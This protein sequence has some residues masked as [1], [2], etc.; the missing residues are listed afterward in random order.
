MFSSA[1]VSRRTL[2]GGAVAA[3]AAGLL[4]ACDSADP[5]P[6]SPARTQE[7]TYVT[8]FGLFGREAYVH[9][10]KAKGYF[11][12]QDLAVKVEPGA[13]GPPNH[14]AVSSGAA[15]FASVDSTGAFE[16]HARGQDDEGAALDDLVVISAVQQLPL[17][18]IITLEGN[19]ITRPQD[20]EGKVV[21]GAAGSVI[22][23][24]FPAYANLAGFDPDSVRFEHT[25]PPQLPQVLAAGQV[26]AIGLFLVGQEAVASV[27]QREAV[28]L[29]Y[30][31]YMPDLYGAV[32]V[33]TAELAEQDPD[34]VRRFNTAILK[35]LEY[36]IA[37]PVEAGEILAESV[38]ETNVEVAASELESM[39]PYVRGGL[40][41]EQPTGVI[42][43]VKV[44]RA[45]T[46]LQGLDLVPPRG[47]DK[48][49]DEHLAWGL[50][51]GTDALNG[52]DQ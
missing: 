33:T 8:A 32:H 39:A 24:M 10:A 31:E 42:D 43:E 30:S 11:A 46:F 15:Q 18:A 4:S 6:A 45:I 34:L 44:T 20:L 2:L 14:Q 52:R 40:G 49:L 50:I 13:G 1:R 26:D 25:A 29:P 37:N 9:V 21:G 47:P 48:I 19:G 16:R 22:E 51:P 28:V 12:E 3:P 5:A 38:P 41:E 27:A 35:G 23:T 36:A 17:M 7:V